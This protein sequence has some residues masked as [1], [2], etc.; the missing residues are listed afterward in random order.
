MRRLTSSA[1]V[2]FSI[3]LPVLAA[4]GVGPLKEK[5]VLLYDQ[6]NYDEARKTL[7]ELDASGALDGPLL[8]RLFFCEKASGHDGEARQALDRARATLEGEMTRQESLETAFYLANTYTNL[9]RAGDASKVASDMTAKIESGRIAA[10]KSGIALFQAGKL[11]QDQSRQNEAM[12]YYQ[13]AVDA[14]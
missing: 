12:S 5:A 10:P 11:Y 9:G 2:V 8:Y 3:V 6:G 14:F 13:K 4:E 7:L 1:A